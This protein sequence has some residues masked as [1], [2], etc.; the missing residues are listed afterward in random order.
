MYSRSY[1]LH[2]KIGVSVNV[3]IPLKD[4]SAADNKIKIKYY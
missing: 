3:S 2:T 4:P 1:V